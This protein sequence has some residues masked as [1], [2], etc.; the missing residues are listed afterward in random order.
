MF[1]TC[2]RLELQRER[3]GLASLQRGGFKPY[4]P[5][6]RERRVRN[7]RRIVVTPA[8]FVGYCFIVIELQWHAARWSPGVLG[9]IMDGVRPARVPDHVIAELRGREKDGC[10][11]LPTAGPQFKA[12]DAVRIKS[13]TFVGLNA[14]V[15]GMRPRERVELLLAALGRVTLPASNIEPAG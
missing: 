2:A 10:V 15:A 12:G 8:L 4:Y 6:I 1:W 9:L 11:E 5:R 7:G 14:L 3:L 13:G